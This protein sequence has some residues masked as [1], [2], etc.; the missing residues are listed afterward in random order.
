MK[1]APVQFY[2]AW[3]DYLPPV[4]LYNKA[5]SAAS[6][7]AAEVKQIAQESAQEAGKGIGEGIGDAARSIGTAIAVSS[8]IL[9]LGIGGTIAYRKL[10]K[11]K[12][13]KRR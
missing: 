2:G 12:G 1:Y 6:S 7:T 13:R 9:I 4:W 11:G 5:T 8:A 10:K 3:Y